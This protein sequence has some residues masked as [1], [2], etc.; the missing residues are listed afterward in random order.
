MRNKRYEV[1]ETFIQGNPGWTEFTMPG[2]GGNFCY[3]GKIRQGC[4]LNGSLPQGR[5][6]GKHS[7]GPGLRP[8]RTKQI[9][10]VGQFA[11]I[12]R[13]QFRKAKIS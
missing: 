7:R 5:Q 12:L 10:G 4:E 11:N 2:C 3:R 6:R 1:R 9:T 8:E 13:K